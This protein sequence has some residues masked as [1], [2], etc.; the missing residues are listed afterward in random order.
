MAGVAARIQMEDRMSGGRLRECWNSGRCAINGWANLGS[1]FAVEI[2][3]SEPFDSITVDMQHGAVD[4]HSALGA[5]LALGGH[6]ATP[7]VR[8]PW[9]DPAAA[10]R[11]L[12]WGAHGLICP[13]V[14]TRE[15]AEKLVSYVR[16]PPQGIRSS[17]PTRAAVSAWPD[18]NRRANDEVICLAM[19]E[20]A[21]AM[22][23][24]EAIVSVPGLDGVYIGP[25]DLTISMTEGRLPAGVDR[26]EPEMMKEIR[27]IRDACHEAGIRVGIHCGASE[28]T[29]A[30][31]QEGYDLVTISSD[32][33]LLREAIRS[34]IVAPRAAVDGA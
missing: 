28:Y 32:T 11:A 13:M 33:G 6:D 22:R 3:A 24:L 9:L 2:L 17:G 14:N 5:L 1:P 8:I 18:Y 19:V 27:R 16:Y 23:N 12:D 20:T 15:D 4:S 30:M 25:S 7:L 26:T 29:V 31:I 10:M 21:E 34:A